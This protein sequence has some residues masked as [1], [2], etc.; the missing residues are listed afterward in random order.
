VIHEKI[1]IDLS[2]IGSLKSVVILFLGP[3]AFEKLSRLQA[4]EGGSIASLI[5]PATQDSTTEPASGSD[6]VLQRKTQV[7]SER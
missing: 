2:V 7:Q 4:R 1:R 5:A 6:R 3:R